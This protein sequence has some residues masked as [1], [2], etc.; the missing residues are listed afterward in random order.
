MVLAIP[1][2]IAEDS[3]AMQAAL[4]DLLQM[5]GPFTVAGSATTE[6]AGTEWLYKN[7]S[8]WKVAILDLVLREGSGFGL[9]RRCKD[10]GEGQV[11]VY[12]EFATPALETKC[13]HLGADAVFLKSNVAGLV[14]FLEGVARTS[15][16][17]SRV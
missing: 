2:F 4:R 7:K 11:I 13:R 12:S 6:M 10:N 8:A 16:V 15:A 9:I 3:I 5:I 17:G 1:V 14:T